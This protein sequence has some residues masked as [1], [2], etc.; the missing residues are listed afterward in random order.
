MKMGYVKPLHIS[1]TIKD[2]KEAIFKNTKTGKEWTFT[3]IP[4]VQ[5]AKLLNDGDY[6][7]SSDISKKINIGETDVIGYIKPLIKKGLLSDKD[8]EFLFDN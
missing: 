3:K 5:I 8:D 4:V 6:H 1:I 2:G 7:S